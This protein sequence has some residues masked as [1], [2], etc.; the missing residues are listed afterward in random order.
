MH[1]RACKHIIFQSYDT[2]TFN[3][4]R[5][6]ENPFTRQCEKENKK[7]KG[8]QILHFYWSF[9]RDIM[10]VKGLMYKVKQQPKF[11]AGMK[12]VYCC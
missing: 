11:P 1:G 2:S 10:A 3:A 4:M 5:F 7:A 6:N 8:F 9:W 12:K